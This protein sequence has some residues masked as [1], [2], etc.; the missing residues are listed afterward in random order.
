ME[1][2]LDAVDTRTLSEAGVD[3]TIMKLDSDVPLR[4]ANGDLV[5]I[6]VLGPD[7]A[8]YR[9][10]TRVQI[11]KRLSRM[12]AGKQT[13]LTEDEVLE[14]EADTLDILAACTLGWAG[15]LTP[16]GEPIPCT[17]ENARKLYENYPLVREQVDQF[18]SQRANF[19]K[20]LS[21]R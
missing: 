11:R 6:K 18:M 16:A 1:F 19:L 20:A 17:Q 4:A 13:E 10:L 3:V 7:S 15:V 9:S 12:A 5:T 14:T 2:A 8:K 21:K